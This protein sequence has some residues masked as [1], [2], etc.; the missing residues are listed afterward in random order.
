MT[1][2][3]AHERPLAETAR[4]NSSRAGHFG[5]RLTP[6]GRLVWHADDD[7]AGLNEAAAIRLGDAFARGDGQGLLQLG[8]GELGQALPPVLAWWRRIRGA[9]RVGF[10]PAGCCTAGRSGAR[11]RRP[12]WAGA[13]GADNDGG[14]IP[15]AR[16]AARPVAGTGTGR[17]RSWAP[18][19][20]VAERRR[21][22]Q[23]T[24]AKLSKTGRPVA[25]VTIEGRKIA[26][27]FWGRAWCDNMESYH[28]YASRLPGGAAMSATDPWSICRW[29][30]A[31]LRRW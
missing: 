31:G 3:R 30:R 8:A 1:S 6:H 9:I 11:R 27:T 2:Q 7:A 24:V 25:P 14:G 20:P 17:G 21:Q 12:R 5:L 28:D 26:T 23:R 18:Y 4:G 22:A 15:V 10:V 13:R 19:V 16:R 29:R